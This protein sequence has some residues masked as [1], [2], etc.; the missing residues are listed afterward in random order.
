VEVQALEQQ[1][2]LP[3]AAPVLELEGEVAAS[4]LVGRRRKRRRMETAPPTGPGV[5]VALALG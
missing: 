1:A 2:L 4:A 5:E 3:P